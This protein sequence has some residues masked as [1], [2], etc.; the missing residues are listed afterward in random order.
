[1]TALTARS[2]SLV[3][4]PAKSDGA[5]L[6]QSDPLAGILPQNQREMRTERTAPDTGLV[7][8]V[9][10]IHSPKE[11]TKA[12]FRLLKRLGPNHDG[13]GAQAP[14]ART[15]DRAIAFIDRMTKYR[16]FFATLDDD[17]SAVIEFDDRAN[18]FFAD[19]TF[20]SDG[21]VECYRRLSGHP[22]LTFVGRLDDADTR[23]FLEN[24]LHIEF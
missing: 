17:G 19:V 6:A 12:R 5:F 16:P 24:E 11:R 22:S 20:L 15:V 23:E 1:M 8:S 18:G 13:E 9:V 21:T 2:F 7:P 4:R 14:N 10:H 3:D